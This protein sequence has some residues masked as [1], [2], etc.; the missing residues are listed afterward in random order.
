MFRNTCRYVA[1]MFGNY[2]APFFSIRRKQRRM[3]AYGHPMPS[4]VMMPGLD[5]R[6]TTMENVGIAIQTIRFPT[7]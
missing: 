6:V 2:A 3:G 7:I 1:I 4:K 5:R